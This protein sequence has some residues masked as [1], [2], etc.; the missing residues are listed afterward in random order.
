MRSVVLY[1][2]YILFDNGKW[3]SIKYLKYLKPMIN[4]SGYERVDL[5]DDKGKRH[6]VFTHIKVIEYFGDCNGNHLP[7]NATSLRELGLSIDHINRNKH[8]N[9]YKNLELVEH[10][11]NCI[12]QSAFNKNKK[13]KRRTKDEICK[14]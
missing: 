11:E 6:R 8:C 2:N 10:K 14:M 9:G 5:C 3:F 7:I 4:S 13:H 12:R 1:N